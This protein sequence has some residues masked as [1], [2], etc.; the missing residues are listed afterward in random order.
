MLKTHTCGELR[1]SNAGETVTLAGW[2]SRRRDH[3]NLV[4]IDLRDRWG[5][6][7]VVADPAVSEEVHSSAHSVRAEYVISVQGSVR[8][9]PEG[10]SNPNLETGEIE[11]LVEK[12]QVLN[13]AKTPPFPIADNGAVDEALRL[14]Y[15]YLDLRRPHMQSNLVLRHRVV[16]YIRD[17]LSAR[18]FV[19]IETPM[20][21]KSTPEGARDYLVPSRI[22]PGSFYAL[23]QS[24]Q[25]LKQLIMVFI[26]P[27]S[28]INLL[29][30]DITFIDIQS[31]SP[32]AQ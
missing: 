32:R 15:R 14:R 24:P 9:R 11:V 16:K 31:Q 27:H 17:Y 6:T 20:L 25:Q 7:Q 10:L 21:F 5:V 23:P 28:L 8:L 13:A 12:L 26:H 4:F 18:D 29:R 3:G 30:V 19:E 1:N 2:V 22:H